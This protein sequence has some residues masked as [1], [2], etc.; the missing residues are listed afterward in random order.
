LL[1]NL[2]IKLIETNKKEKKNI[3]VKLLVGITDEIVDMG[4]VLNKNNSIEKI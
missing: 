4:Y 3:D 2:I 1:L